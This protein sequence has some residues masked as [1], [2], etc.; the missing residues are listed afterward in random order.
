MTYQLWIISLLAVS[1]G[2]TISEYT[3]KFVWEML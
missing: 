3:I 2:R 1:D